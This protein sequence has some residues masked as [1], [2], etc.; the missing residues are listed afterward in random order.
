MAE[1]HLTTD[2]AQF[3]AADMHRLI[4]RLHDASHAFNTCLF[5]TCNPIEF[6]IHQYNAKMSR[7][8][9]SVAKKNPLDWRVFQGVQAER[10]S[11]CTED[12]F[13]AITLQSSDMQVVTDAKGA[14]TYASE[15]ASRHFNF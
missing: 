9:L 10:C 1:A 3:R 14:I 15:T 8:N 5:S 6:A 13:K 4:I 7:Q 11:K 12:F 2:S